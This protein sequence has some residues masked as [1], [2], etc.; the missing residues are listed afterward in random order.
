MPFRESD[1]VEQREALVQAWKSGMYRVADL[2]RRFGVSRPTVYL[3]IERQASDESLSDR[4]RTPH[5]FPHQTDPELMDEVLRLRK[6]HPYWGTEEAGGGAQIP[7][8]GQGMASAEHG[9]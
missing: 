2:A 5:Q 4:S 9:R 6:E 1:R 7:R 3:W 8:T